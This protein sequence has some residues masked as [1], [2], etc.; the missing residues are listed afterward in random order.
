[1]RVKQITGTF[2]TLLQGL[3][4]LLIGIC[5]TAYVA[6]YIL[7]RMI[8]ER[9]YAGKIAG[10]AHIHCIGQRLDRGFRGIDSRLKI[11]EEYV[12]GVVGG[13]ET[14]HGQSHKP[15]EKSGCYIAEITAGNAYD[16]LSLFA[17]AFH[18]RICI[19]VVE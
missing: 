11:V 4:N 17:D 10:V 15:G 6:C 2:V 9:Q 19:E 5:G 7:V 13:N 18:L 8:I 12:I 3:S 14:L 1:M 16:Q